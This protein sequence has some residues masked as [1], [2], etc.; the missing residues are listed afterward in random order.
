M[1]LELGRDLNK[2]T[3]NAA[4]AVSDLIGKANGIEIDKAAVDAMREAFTNINLGAKIVVGE[5][6]KDEAPCFFMDEQVGRKNKHELDLAIDP[7]EGTEFAAEAK[8]NAVAVLA[9]TE[10]GKMLRVPDMYMDKIV[11]GPA[12]KGKIN[13]NKGVLENLAIIAGAKDTS[14]DELTVAVL[15]R[16]RH[17][18][19]I[20]QI[21]D[22][23]A[24]VKLIQGADLIWSIAAVRGIAG[25]D[26]LMGTGGAPE[27]ILT[28]AAVKCLGGDMV[29]KLC[30]QNK[31]EVK[32]AKKLGINDCNQVFSLNDMIAGDEIVF[33]LTGVTDGILVDGIKDGITQSIVMRK[34]AASKSYIREMETDY[35]MSEKLKIS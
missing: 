16:K 26:L 14:I 15:D 23:G 20:N 5:G 33:S 12:A 13:L 35:L 32:E 21:N 2:I 18:D 10:E 34:E 11:V 7:I 3:E 25:V 4:L 1:G 31:K 8:P 28:A 24:Q 9:G 27:G 17:E 30:P 19:L 6:K 22:A 29:T